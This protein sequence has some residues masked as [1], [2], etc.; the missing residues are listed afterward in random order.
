MTGKLVDGPLTIH[1]HTVDLFGN[2]AVDDGLTLLDT[3]TTITLDLA[4]E[5]DSGASQTDDLTH[6][7]RPLLQGKGEPGATVTLTLGNQVLAVLTVDGAGNWQF[8]IPQTLA[9]GSYDFKV[10]SV[11]IAGNKASDTLTVTVDTQAGIDIDDLDAGQ[12]WGS[13]NATLSGTVTQVEPGQIVSI[14]LNGAGQPVLN[15]QATVGADGRWQVDGLDLSGFKG[16]IAIKATVTDLAGNQVSDGVPL[17][18]QSD[19]LV[20]FEA[21]LANGPISQIGQLNTGAGVDGGLK[22][23]LAV[24]QS[25]LESL[26]LTSHGALLTYQQ[27]S[28]GLVASANGQPVFTLT[29]NNNG[30]YTLTWQQSLDHGQ[31]KL[32]LPFALEYRDSDGDLVEAPLHIALLDSTPPD[33]QVPALTLTEDAFQEAS[34]VVGIA[35]F[36]VKHGADPILANTLTFVEQAGVLAGLQG[37]YSSDGH[38]LTFEFV[39]DL[40]LSGYYL[41]GNGQRVEV[42]QAKLSASQNGDDVKG[43]VS[44][45]LT[46]PLDHQGSDALTLGLKVGAVE[47]DGDA[48]SPAE[49]QIT[50]QDGRDPA[51]GIDTGI[52]LQEGAAGQ[53]LDGQLPVNVGSDRLVSLNFEGNQPALDGLTSGGKPTSYQVNGN[54][55]TLLDAGGKTV[56]TVTLDLDGKYHVQLDGVLDQPVGTNSVNLGLQVQ[57]TDFDG[58]QSNLGTLN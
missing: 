52:S 51:L 22:V 42:L 39:D 49:L 5:S 14:S 7:T 17:V 38:P 48:T 46:G 8:P 13:N 57:G 27:G 12:L 45:S 25:A 6:D 37:Q 30:T 20:L 9:D 50:I 15:V 34:A 35:Q 32:V 58:D 53:S 28:Q 21:D 3:I 2:E 40:T 44:V 24:D 29:V 36:D 11:D 55:I 41:D 1:A 4:D 56:L 54:V 10:D 16:P 18:G 43:E 19:T 33:F 23:T 31:D 26:H 47:I